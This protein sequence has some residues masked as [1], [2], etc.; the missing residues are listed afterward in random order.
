M[1]PSSKTKAPKEVRA[2]FSPAEY[3]KRLQQQT[4]VLIPADK[5]DLI[6]TQDH[7]RGVLQEQ[8]ST[9]SQAM[10]RGEMIPPIIVTFR[11]NDTLALLD[12]MQ[13]LTSARQLK[14][15]VLA[16]ALG[17]GSS[18]LE[19]EHFL[20]WHNI[21][22]VDASISTTLDSH[23]EELKELQR[24]NDLSTHI[25]H[26]KVWFGKTEADGVVTSEQPDTSIAAATLLRLT[27]KGL[28]L[29][30][31]E[32]CLQFLGTIAP[33]N[34]AH[35]S[36]KYASLLGILA[37]YNSVKNTKFDIGEQA[38]ADYIR[39]FPWGKIRVTARMQA[40]ALTDKVSAKILEYWGQFE[41]P[42]VD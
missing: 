20:N 4:L 14:Y 34:Q 21:K 6:K 10:A 24:I 30:D 37:A 23:N 41:K 28:A 27:K 25:L 39:Q 36:N 2:I 13:R 18:R 1:P 5:L 32:E 22:R 29:E 3:E 26:K 12:G 16:L 38:H 9:I 19:K 31:M 7:P 33:I 40:Q 8:V 17:L 15:P 42:V 35:V 11:D